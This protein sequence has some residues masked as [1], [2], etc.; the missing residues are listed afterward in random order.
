MSLH[1]PSP[2]PRLGRLRGRLSRRGQGGL[3]LL[4]TLIG[5]TLSGLLISPMMAW[6]AVSMQQQRAIVQRNLSGA[7]LGVLRT[8]FTRDV[9]NA[10]RV[11]VDGE[12][13]A[14][15][16]VPDKGA[17]TL[18]V[19]VTGDRHTTYAVVPDPDDGGSRLVRAQ[20]PRAGAVAALA[21]ELVGDVLPAGT[22]VTCATGAQL[23]ELS[24][25]F[26]ADAQARGAEVSAVPDGERRGA[27]AGR[28]P[29]SSACG[30]VTLRL[31]TSALE[32]VALSASVRPAAPW[33]CPNPRSRPSA[34][35]LSRAHV[36]SPSP[37]MVPA[38]ATLGGRSSPSTGT[39]A[40]ARP[41]PGCGSGTTTPGPGRSPPPS[42]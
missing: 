19:L 32:Q 28:D 27:D 30:H 1:R 11:W 22:D 20:C 12:H 8:V 37:S 7:S 17:D 2:A 5:V 35:V 29:D 34:P 10:D 24:R 36:R 26:A 16:R 40:M 9:L 38:R 23:E 6:A 25:T 41:V 42:R 15:C 3:S 39:S 4:E 13:L 31:S 14:D 21:N 18:M 33:P